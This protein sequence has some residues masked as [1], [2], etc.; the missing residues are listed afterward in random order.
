MNKNRLFFFI[1]LG[2]LMFASPQ[3]FTVLINN[4]EYC[5]DKQTNSLA[6]I[7][8]I[9]NS[10]NL[11]RYLETKDYSFEETRVVHEILADC[12]ADNEFIKITIYCNKIFGDNTKTFIEQREFIASKTF[13]IILNLCREFIH[14]DI[15]HRHIRLEAKSFCIKEKEGNTLFIWENGD[16]RYFPKFFDQ[17]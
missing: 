14:E 11:Q 16:V 17:I 7:N 9:L 3:V 13:E 5:I 12:N 10:K 15:T 6:R 1:L 8:T 4:K 2:L